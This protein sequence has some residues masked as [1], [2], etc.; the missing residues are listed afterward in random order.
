MPHTGPQVPVVIC[1]YRQSVFDCHCSVCRCAVATDIRQIASSYCRISRPQRHTRLWTQLKC[2]T[3]LCDVALLGAAELRYATVL[4]GVRFV[5]SQRLSQ[6]KQAC[7]FLVNFAPSSKQ[8]TTGSCCVH[9]RFVKGSGEPLR[10][11]LRLVVLLITVASRP[12]CMLH[13]IA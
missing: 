7:G 1:E 12:V 3:R 9:G 5:E 13:S 11:V 10:A 6:H 4:N 2:I 8:A